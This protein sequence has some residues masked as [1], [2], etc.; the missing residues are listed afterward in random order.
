MLLSKIK[1][2]GK[3]SALIKKQPQQANSNNEDGTEA[4]EINAHL[5]TDAIAMKC[6][7][8]FMELLESRREISIQLKTTEEQLY[9]SEEKFR[10]LTNEKEFL[11][12]KIENKE[13]EI[14]R[15][16]EQ[17]A[18]SKLR[19]DELTDEFQ[20]FRDESSSK[21]QQ[22][23]NVLREQELA[24]KQL[25]VDLNRTRSESQHK[26][27]QLEAKLREERTKFTHL[28]EQYEQVV[29]ENASLIETINDFAQRAA[30]FSHFPLEAQK[31]V[32]DKNSNV[33]ELK[34][35]K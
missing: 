14:G 32:K 9:D 26:I 11:E 31:L 34:S 28:L 2:I 29:K 10:N 5:L 27:E 6:F 15:L 21:Y 35:F 30:A 18:T 19:I 25:M 20:E 7:E 22:L 1:D 8:S 23:Q 17:L 12:E 13:L 24:N 3:V 4:E 33:P 16:Q